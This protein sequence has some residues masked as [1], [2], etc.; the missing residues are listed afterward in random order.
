MRLTD[1]MDDSRLFFGIAGAV[2]TGP[3]GEFLAFAK[4]ADKLP[5]IDNLIANPSS[6]MPSEDPAVLYALTGAVASRAKEST[7]ENIMKLSKKI[8][9]EFQV[10]LVKSMLAIDKALFQLQAIQDWVKTNADVVL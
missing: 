1:N 9:T 5:D 10:V 7:L 6:Y 2:G 8:P 4:I 3:A